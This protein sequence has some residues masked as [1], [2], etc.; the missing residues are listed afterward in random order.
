M[1][2]NLFLAHAR[3]T[4]LYKQLCRVSATD[5]GNL[6]EHTSDQVAEAQTEFLRW[7]LQLARPKVIVETRAN[8]GLF[9]YF[10]SLLLHDVVLHTLGVHPGA[11]QAVKTLNAGQVN[12]S[13]IFYEGDSRVTFPRLHVQADFAW[14]GGGHQHDVMLSDLLQC[15]RLQIPYVAVEDATYPSVRKE[16]AYTL[17]HFPYAVLPNPFTPNDSRGAMLLHLSGNH[18]GRDSRPAQ[19][20]VDR[21]QNTRVESGSN[22][23]P[24]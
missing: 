2:M 18:E 14:L 4:D 13:C 15:Y 8:K 20:F 12:V 1:T 24:V 19:S 21:P 7:A 9:G 11:A 10:V 16:V 23:T 3:S 17:D 6:L 22:I 5:D